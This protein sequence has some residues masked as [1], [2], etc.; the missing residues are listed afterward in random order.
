MKSKAYIR[1]DDMTWPTPEE[2][3]NDLAWKFAHDWDGLTRAD[4]FFAVS[5]MEAYNQL[6]NLPTKKRNKVIS[7]MK[8]AMNAEGKE[9]E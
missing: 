4:H 2:I 6:I 7:D 1:F 9:Q 3:L 8:K 5:V